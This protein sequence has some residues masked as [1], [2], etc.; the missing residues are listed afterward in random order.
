[1]ISFIVA[2]DERG[3]IGKNNNIP[4]HLPDD[5]KRFKRITMGHKIVMGRKTFESIGKPLPGRENIVLSTNPTFHCPSCKVFRD[6]KKL[7]DYCLHQEEEI[8]VIGGSKIFQLFLPF[9]EKLYITRI[10]HTFDGDVFF[11]D[12][13][14]SKF[15]ILS[16]EKGM[17]DEKNPYDYEY[18]VYQKNN[19]D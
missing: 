9:V 17:K 7:L 11:P 18:I 8:F 15:T 16:R 3:V 12:C 13:N 2:M 14:W 4:W 5:L 19:S 10:Y 6:S 1:M